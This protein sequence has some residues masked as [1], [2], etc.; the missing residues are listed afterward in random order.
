MKRNIFRIYFGLLASC[1]FLTTAC[2]EEKLNNEADI[3][4]SF[5]VKNEHGKV[6]K[7]TIEN[8]NIKLKVS[9]YLDAE[10]EL[11]KAVPVF[12]LSKGATVSPD[13]SIP[14]NFA[15]TGGVKYTVKSEDGSNSHVYTVTWGVSDKL[16]YGE[17]FSY[18]E[19]GAKKLFPELGYPGEQGNFNLPDSKEYGD[20]ILYHAYCGDNIVLLSRAYINADPASPHG[21]KVVNKNTLAD[22]GSLNMGSISQNNLKLITSDYKGNCVGAVVSG[23]ETEIFYWT[24]TTSAPKSAGKIA[25]NMALSTDGSA[26]FQVAGNITGNAWITALAPRD[27]KGTH[28]RIKVTGGKLASDYSTVETGYASDDCAGF[29]M[30]APLDDSDAPNFIVGDTEGTAAAANSIHAYINTFSGSTLYTM[31]PLWQNILQ[32]WWV[33]T[34]FSTARTGGRSPVV[35]A[36]IINGKSYVVVTSGTGWWHAAAVL[37]PDLQNLAHENLNIAFGVN[38]NWSFGSWVDWYW[39]DDTSEAY[40]AVWFGRLG[41]YTYKLT[42]FE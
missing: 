22:A 37:T 6:F 7:S 27:K 14:Q 34:G 19:I 20:L 32:T 28:Y 39:N 17:G 16:P 38:R 3:I 13:P 42:C 12:Y 41:L 18:A 11:A 15:Q 30:I 5:S 25:V 26:N 31:P 21:V 23:N 10:E 24:S 29:Q 35:S 1:L 2:Q 8:D 4:I 40:L 33:G 36:L 9:P